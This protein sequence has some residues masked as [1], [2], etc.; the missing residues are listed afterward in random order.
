[1][2]APT[3]WELM[4]MAQSST[5]LRRLRQ[6][7]KGN[8]MY[9]TAG[10]LIPVL[11]TIGAG[12]DL[13][14]AYMAKARLQQACDAGVLAGRR[15]MA[16]GGFNGQARQ[17]AE[18]MFEFNYPDDI[19]E[20]RNVNFDVSSSGASDVS[21]TA[22]ATVDTIIMHMFGKESFALE[23][24]CAARLEIANS[25]I[26]FVLDT[27]GSMLE[28]NPGDVQNRMS[29]MRTEVMA[30]Y[31]TMASASTGSAQIRYGFVPYSSNVN[32]GQILR[33]A[34]PSWVS[35][36]IT[37]PSRTGQFVQ[38]GSGGPTPNNPAWSAWSTYAN[39]TPIQ[40]AS[41]R[42]SANCA[43]APGLPPNSVTQGA[44]SAP[45]VTTTGTNPRTTT[46]STTRPETES[47]HRWNWNNTGG[48]AASCRLQ[49]RTRT[50]TVTTSS[51]VTEEY[52]YTYQNMTYDVGSAIG[53]G[54][55]TFP[56][57]T[58]GANVSASWN[59]CIVERN[60]VAFGANAAVPNGALDLD[61]DMIPSSEASRW[62]GHFPALAHPRAANPYDTQGTANV[63]TT[64]D[65]AS[66]T[67]AA[68]VSGGW[69]A[70]PSPAS[71]LRPYPS[72]QR[73]AMQAYV[74]SLVA[75]GG[76]YHD[77]GMVWGA[78]L[79]SPTGLFA[80]DNAA[81]P[82]GAPISRHIIF[83]TDGQMAPN[84]GIYGFQGQEYTMGRVGSTSTTELTARHNARFQHAC[85]Q[86]KQRNITV[87]VIAFG[88]T[89]NADM[90][91]CASGGSAFQANNST[92]LRQRFQQIA[93]QITRLRLQQ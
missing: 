20:S 27:T 86:A 91:Q 77:V 43:S 90:T 89:L 18:Q 67:S 75:V 46:T 31:D 61:I 70:C 65:W 12:V 44:T 49:R 10:L 47:N 52:R 19:Y 41:G 88:T 9:L 74:N 24:D 72:S 2:C 64:S 22:S 60:T 68:N 56:T 14:Q 25:D 37:I 4:N 13:G 76:T 8:V 69:A 93:Q 63:T 28:V 81:A 40:V 80:S 35:N 84:P 92:Q 53:G 51:F 62:R 78:R 21:G 79:I 26:M 45:T 32:V 36:S 11:A 3:L 30:F 6:D 82:N 33:A 16:D 39:L 29:A 15:E 59:G 5:L 55:V 57:G 23:V 42:T 66:Y 85:T 1:M 73:A 58:N 54:S 87:W 71:R 17:A 38:T 34:N 83:M 48:G 7:R 50:R